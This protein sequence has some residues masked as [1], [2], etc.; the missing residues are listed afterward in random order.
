MKL[1]NVLVALSLVATAAC[2]ASPT[3]P[4]TSRAAPAS[5]AQFDDTPTPD[6][7]PATD[8]TARG[9]GTMGSGG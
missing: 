6:P 1:R 8:T 5:S 7:V 4:D 9:G 3:A 2:Q